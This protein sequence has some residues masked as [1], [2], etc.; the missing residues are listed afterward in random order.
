M[1]QDGGKFFQKLLNSY[2]VKVILSKETYEP[3][4]K[5]LG[6]VSNFALK[7]IE[8]FILDKHI[9]NVFERGLS[10]LLRYLESSGGNVR[11]RHLLYEQGKISGLGFLLRNTIARFGSRKGRIVTLVRFIYSYFV[12]NRNYRDLLITTKASRLLITS[13]T[14]FSYDAPLLTEAKRLGIKTF[15]T[16]RSWDNLVS[17]GSLHDLPDFFFSHSRYMTECAIKYQFIPKEKILNVGVS[18]YKDLNRRTLE[19]KLSYRVGIGCVGPSHPTEVEF[20]RMCADSL[21]PEFPQ[22]SF[23]VVQHPK[24]V[25]LEFPDLSSC[26][27]VQIVRFLF[28]DSSQDTLGNYYEF[29][30]SLDILFTSGSTIGLDAMYCGTPLICNFFDV[31]ISPFWASASRFLSHRTHYR[32]FIERTGVSLHLS[33]ESFLLFFSNYK[34]LV[35]KEFAKFKDPAEF[36]GTDFGDFENNILQYL[37]L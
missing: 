31:S 12:L 3:A 19:K 35:S 27:N 33:Y 8:T 32:D 29:L 5:F 25:Q 10:F 4:M 36:T 6:T 14:N 18:T 20:L 15:G 28:D 17:H 13:L 9:P 1:F 22:I 7:D 34:E 11:L 21:F 26:S 24:F 30:G 2:D 37:N 23:F 16:P